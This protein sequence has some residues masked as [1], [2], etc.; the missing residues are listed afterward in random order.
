[1]FNWNMISEEDRETASVFLGLRDQ[2]S[3]SLMPQPDLTISPTGEPYLYRWH[4]VP[5][6]KTQANIYLHIQV[7]D[8]YDRA[9]HDHPWHNQSVI[10]SG[11]YIEHLQRISPFGEVL[12]Y[13]RK[14]GDV[15][16]RR[17]EQAH[18]LV[19]LPGVPYAMTLFTTG[20][21]ER[22]WGF[23]LSDTRWVPHEEVV[24]R[25]TGPS[26]LKGI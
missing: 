4:C 6:R 15:I 14:K 8:D 10:L 16:Q 19:M 3:P 12:V 5:R 9:L 18:R 11:G 1:M 17:A 21:V 24:D 22:E 20:P 2:R 13:T 26:I 7:S 25:S 23:W